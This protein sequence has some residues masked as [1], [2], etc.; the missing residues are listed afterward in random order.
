MLMHAEVAHGA[1]CYARCALLHSCTCSCLQPALPTQNITSWHV[2][3]ILQP[4]PD[5][6][7]VQVAGEQRPI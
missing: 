6:E 7:E 4:Q 2:V 5:R 1:V 3:P